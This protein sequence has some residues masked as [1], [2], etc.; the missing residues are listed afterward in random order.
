MFRRFKGLF[1]LLAILCVTAIAGGSAYFYF[2]GKEKKEETI[3]NSL[4]S[5][6]ESGGITADNILENYEFGT[7]KDLNEEYTYYFFPSTLY[8]ELYKNGQNPETVF[9][10][11]EVVLDDSGDPALTSD[12]QPMYNIV[13]ENRV[14]VKDT[15]YKTY[16][17]YLVNSLNNN[18]SYY[19]Y[20][21]VIQTSDYSTGERYYY[22]SGIHGNDN[23]Y[24]GFLDTLADPYIIN[25]KDAYNALL[26]NQY[27][28]SESYFKSSK[29]THVS[30]REAYDL[31]TFV[32]QNGFVGGDGSVDKFAFSKGEEYLSPIYGDENFGISRELTEGYKKNANMFA[33]FYQKKNSNQSRLDSV[34]ISKVSID[35]DYGRFGSH[36]NFDAD[37]LT[38]RTLSTYLND[39]EKTN[40]DYIDFEKSDSK[41]Q[42]YIGAWSSP[43]QDTNLSL[44][45]LNSSEG[46]VVDNNN[47]TSYYFK[48]SVDSNGYCRINSD[49]VSGHFTITQGDPYGQMMQKAQYR[50]DRF[51]FWTPFYD[52]DD[53]KNES[54]LGKTEY[55]A[56]RYLP[57][58]ITVNGNLTPDDMA[59]IIPSV[60]SSMFDSHLYFDFTANGWTYVK[61]S[62]SDLKDS[63]LEYKSAV[64]GF[65]AKDLK[66]I[67]DI[68]Q[69][70][71]KYADSNNV[72]R[73]FPVFSNGK[74]YNSSLTDGGRDSLRAD[75]KYKNNTST[76]TN[77]TNPTSTK[78]TYSSVTYT[79]ASGN[80]L[81]LPDYSYDVNYAVLNN[82]D[83][84]KDKYDSITIKMAAA[85]GIHNWG[86]DWYDLYSI[87]G[88]VINKFVDVF[89]EGLY[90][91]YLFIGNSASHNGTQYNPTPFPMISEDSL[92]SYI[93]N[94]LNY[95]SNELK[96]K[97]LNGI[98]DSS[99]NYNKSATSS[100]KFISCSEAGYGTI[101][102]N[103]RPIGLAVE[104]V[105]NLRLVTDIPIDDSGNQDWGSIDSNIEQGLI[106]AQNFTIADDVYEISEENYL[107]E[108][109]NNP[110]G[111]PIDS[112][113]PYIY[114]IQ[115]ADFRFV[116]NL[117]FQI[118]FSNK[119]IDGGMNVTTDYKY[120]V[121]KAK[122]PKYLAYKIQDQ[123]IKFKFQET[124]DK[125]VFIENATVKGSGGVTRDGFKLKD[126]NARGIYDILLVTTSDEGG[127]RAMNM[128]VNR[129]TNSFIKLFNGYPG[130]FES[131]INLGGTSVDDIFVRHKLPSEDADQ[132]RKDTSQ[133]LWNGQTYLGEYL[134]SNS[135][136]DEY[137]KNDGTTEERPS[138]ESISFLEAIKNEL[139]VTPGNDTIYPIKDAVTG[140]SIA[141]Y[142][143]GV[144]RLYTNEGSVFDDKTSLNLFTIMKN[145]VLYIERLESFYGTWTGVL[146]GMNPSDVTI[147]INDDMTGSYNGRSFNYRVK[148]NKIFGTTDDGTYKITITYI[149]ET[150]KIEVH[151]QDPSGGHAFS[152]TLSDYKPAEGDSSE[153]TPESSSL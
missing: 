97:H 19:L 69:H 35:Y 130:T 148:G 38:N 24:M 101:G 141:Y 49:E 59:K 131:K 56:S 32:Y 66:Y 96:F 26:Y 114:I 94:K 112:T 81:S 104:K 139:G 142:N 122:T 12:G 57:I 55:S 60:E 149:P 10:Y 16:Y 44:I 121:D 9:G 45:L 123:L 7:N 53:P 28:G 107:K 27:V 15:S 64:G 11:N 43:T 124:E 115:N 98:V 52:W 136:G 137:V 50:N 73:L 103:D 128:Y 120:V 99:N 41:S 100:F 3:D 78:L 72:I 74:N 30:G 119:Y 6:N 111:T 68:M 108:D 85:Y 133:L 54:T 31:T 134:T 147:V 58:K 22:G 146:E 140:R 13:T 37:E 82:V 91:F 23:R 14:G 48:Y 144:G 65:T 77:S 153:T 18:S 90:T 34:S 67:F 125:D 86:E 39:F 8:M 127:K 117:Y 2:G 135:K 151:V 71:S 25:N 47:Y 51:G 46:Y 132:A 42:N 87:S 36:S 80:D 93:T 126:Y 102:A 62:G 145:Y 75:F 110:T 92:I 4:D 95:S 1:A 83:L 5:G 152:G 20:G 29:E 88:S 61:K 113:N 63:E 79:S 129:H 76:I 105:T 106:N 150:Q 138:G 109:F 118:R 84:Q 89:G 17:D 21:N 143:S 40:L 116:N 70:P 33:S